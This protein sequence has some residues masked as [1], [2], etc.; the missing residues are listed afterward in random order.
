[1]AEHTINFVEGDGISIQSSEAADGETW[2][3]EIAATLSGLLEAKGDLLTATDADTPA[4]LLAGADGQVLTADTTAATGLKWATAGGGGT[5]T[6]AFYEQTT[7]PAGAP[8]GA[9]WV[10]TDG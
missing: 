5:G 7:A 2:D 8:L 6:A 3:V 4:R 1:M 9:V 10:D